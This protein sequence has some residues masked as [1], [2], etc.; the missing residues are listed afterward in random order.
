MKQCSR[1]RVHVAALLMVALLALVGCGAGDSGV[2]PVGPVG[3][4]VPPDGTDIVGSGAVVAETRPVGGFDQ[5]VLEGEGDVSIRSTGKDTLVVRTDDNLQQL[6]ETVVEGRA[7]ILRKAEDVDLAPTD[8]I[9]YE[10]TVRELAG[11]T[12]AG[13]GSITVDEWTA[14]NSRLALSG[15]GD[16]EVGKLE[17]STLAVEYTGVGSISIADGSVGDQTVRLDGVGDYVADALATET[18]S[19]DAA[20]PVSALVWVTDTL[21]I[22]AR[23]G[24]SVS[25]YGSPVVTEAL[26]GSSSATAL[27]DKADPGSSDTSTT[28]VTEEVRFTSGGFELVGELTRPGPDGPY[29]AV[30][31]V[32]GSGPQTRT[33][34]PGTSTILERFG[35]AGYAVLVWD[36]P[37][38][39]EST[40]EFE[41]GETLRQRAAI[42]A[43]GVAFLARHPQIDD[44]RIGLWGLSQ[45]GWVMPLTLALT[46]DVAFMITVSGGGEDSIEQLAYQLGQDVVCQGNPAGDAAVVEANFPKAAKGPTYADYLEA[47]ELLVEVEGWEDF[48]GPEFKEE[49]EWQPWP[50]H[51]DAYFDPMPTI[52][53]TTI[54]VLAVFGEMDRYVD[55]IQG[56]SAYEDALEVAGNV[57]YRVELL[58]GVGHTM[59][60]QDSMCESGTTMSSAYLELL[61]AWVADLDL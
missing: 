59:L 23:D 36:K 46:D 33:S 38:S 56:A 9:E 53:R 16:I 51:I 42:L 47:M 6:I 11:V 12:L 1:G 21:S 60:E 32:H 35:A 2:G 34:T 54:P 27:G 49:H 3:P 15:A 20:G 55:P 7:L 30:I 45:G 48:I 58:P 24:A 37:G 40:G 31:I 26:E 5:I 57:H 41:Q 61:D 28:P 14:E 25:Y 17:A 19:V 39:G 13:A 4:V 52:E 8:S 18:A 43:D 10:V 29:P 22:V 50:N 44:S